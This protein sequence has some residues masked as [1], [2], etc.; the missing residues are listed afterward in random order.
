MFVVLIHCGASVLDRV[1]TVGLSD[2]VYTATKKMRDL[3]VNS[4]VITTNNKPQGILTCESY[5]LQQSANDFSLRRFVYS[6]GIL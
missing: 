1:A 3:R 4:V 2:T 5:L 6:K